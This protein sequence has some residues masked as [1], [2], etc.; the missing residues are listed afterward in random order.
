MEPSV[1][2]SECGSPGSSPRLLRFLTGSGAEGNTVGGVV[3][4]EVGASDCK[5]VTVD[6]AGGGGD[7]ELMTE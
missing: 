3:T 6:A 2:K 1:V 5:D 4:M 7:V